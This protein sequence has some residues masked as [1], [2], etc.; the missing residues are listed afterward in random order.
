VKRI[1]SHSLS[2]F[3]ITV[4][5]IPTLGKAS[6][7][8]FLKLISSTKKSLLC[9]LFFAIR[10]EARDLVTQTLRPLGSTFCHIQFVEKK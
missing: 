3:L 10:S 6:S 9:A 4:L 7:T 8:S 1:T 2:V 5:D